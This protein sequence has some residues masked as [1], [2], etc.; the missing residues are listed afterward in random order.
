MT[1]YMPESTQD[2]R[3]YIRGE[4]KKLKELKGFEGFSRLKQL[5]GTML[6]LEEF[7]TH[8]DETR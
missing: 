4:W 6:L 8:Q 7:E 3:D 5:E 2:I 1:R